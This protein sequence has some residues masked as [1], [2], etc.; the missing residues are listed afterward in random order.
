MWTDVAVV[1]LATGVPVAVTVIGWPRYRRH[2]DREELIRSELDTGM[3][4]L[5]E[6]LARAGN[7]HWRR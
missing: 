7:R 5:E 2:R 3:P 1:A 6:Y 4:E